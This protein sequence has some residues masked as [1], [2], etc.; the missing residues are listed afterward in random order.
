MVWRRGR[1]RTALR[2]L[3][4]QNGN[5]KRRRPANG[6]V[7]EALLLLAWVEF[8]SVVVL[9]EMKRRGEVEKG[10]IARSRR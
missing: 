9:L 3:E 8:E 4:P 5:L 7:Y 2:H 10:F 1:G 6:N